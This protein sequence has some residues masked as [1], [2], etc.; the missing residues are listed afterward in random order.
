MIRRVI[1]SGGGVSMDVDAAQCEQA[2]TF[3]RLHN[4]AVGHACLFPWRVSASAS[5]ARYCTTV[6]ATYNC[7][8]RVHGRKVVASLRLA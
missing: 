8:S 6:D 7:G 5:V 3:A 1:D 2:P 4:G